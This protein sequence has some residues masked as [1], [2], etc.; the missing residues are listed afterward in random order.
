MSSPDQSFR[1]GEGPPPGLGPWREGGRVF[2][3]VGAPV[4]GLSR[5]HTSSPAAAVLFLHGVPG[6]LRSSCVEALAS[7]KST[8]FTSPCLVMSTLGGLT[9]R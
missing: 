2:D 5:G 8:I 3:F 9:S 6:S 1:P 7:P 4:F